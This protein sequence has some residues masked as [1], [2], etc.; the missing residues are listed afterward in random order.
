MTEEQTI[1]LFLQQ[2]LQVLKVAEQE[3]NLDLSNVSVIAAPLS[4][5]ARTFYEGDGMV[6]FNPEFIL[7]HF[8]AM[9]ENAIAHELAHIVVHHRPEYGSGHDLGWKS[10]KE[11]L[12]STAEL[13][14][15]LS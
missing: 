13:V 12:E 14:G 9:V 1:K 6:V 10:I 5:P 3:F 7:N 8:D 11:H 15:S 4:V 2:V